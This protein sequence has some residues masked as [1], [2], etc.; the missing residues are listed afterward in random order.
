VYVYMCC[1]CACV[2]ACARVCARVRACVHVCACG[3]ASSLRSCGDRTFTVSRVKA[4]LA[5]QNHQPNLRDLVGMASPAPPL[6]SSSRNRLLARAL[7]LGA[8]GGAFGS[9]AGGVGAGSL[10][11]YLFADA[12]RL[13]SR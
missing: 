4:I 7:S 6:S 10:E 13:S 9:S 2:C 1:T 12:V 8:A 11:K 3:L 5:K